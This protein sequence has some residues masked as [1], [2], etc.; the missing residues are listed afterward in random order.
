MIFKTNPLSNK[1]RR[2]EEK[3]IYTGSLIS[4]KCGNSFPNALWLQIR[5]LRR[6]PIFA[7]NINKPSEVLQN[8]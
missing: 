5:W 1:I 2:V 4:A 8:I 3:A 6:K 7:K